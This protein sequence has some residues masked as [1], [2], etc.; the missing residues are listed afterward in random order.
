MSIELNPVGF[1]QTLIRFDTTNPPGNEILAINWAR[2]LLSAAGIES[3]ILAKDP[4]RPNL[5][6]R[7]KGSGNA[8]PL[9]LQGHVDV[10]TT[11]GQ[12][13]SHP[14]F[15]GDL[16]DGYIWGR[17]ALDMKGAVA[18][19][20]V[21]F[22][23]AYLENLPLPGDVI[24]CLLADEEAGG[25]FGAKFLVDEHPQLFQGVKYALGEAGG[26]SLEIAGKTFYPIMIAEKQICWTRITIRGPGGHGSMV[27]K[28]GAMAR[29]GKILNILDRKRLP[30]HITPPVMEMFTSIA[31]GLSFPGNVLINQLLNPRFTDRLLDILGNSGKLFEPLFHNNINATI[32]RGGNKINVIPSEITLDL[33]GRLLPGFKPDHLLTELRTLLGQD[34]EIAIVRYDPGPSEPDMGLFSTLAKILKQ[35]DPGGNPVPL[36]MMGVT[37]ARHFSRLGI[38]T[39]G[40]T[41]MKLP[42]A[43]NFTR[44]AHG[45]DERIP[46]DALAFGTDAIRMALMQF[47][48]G[49]SMR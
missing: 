35:K 12:D 7:I 46:V 42:Q 33:D 43:L 25:D 22:L 39:Y 30:V 4:N 16:T 38:Q 23:Q 10:V 37:D 21:A 2:D 8:P 17:G 3:T 40:F 45:A 27:H 18:M 26:F 49:V 36:V 34:L 24:L 31:Q 28:G 5:I 32:V 1:L 14:P 19:M 11:E 44:L 20:M 13:W 6:A 41:P 48:N 15:E 47:S 29:L 9:L